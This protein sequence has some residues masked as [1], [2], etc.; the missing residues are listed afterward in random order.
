MVTRGR[1]NGT[2]GQSHKLTRCKIK[3]CILHLQ[4]QKMDV[5]FVA[6]TTPSG[7]RT[8]VSPVA[9]AY[10]TTRPTVLEAVNPPD[11]RC[12][13]SR[14]CATSIC[15]P[16]VSIIYRMLCFANLSWHHGAFQYVCEINPPDAGSLPLLLMI[17]KL[18]CVR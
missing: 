13:P 10:S 6:I 12:C 7:N 4:N 17:M 3:I 9:G 14:N 18:V 8:R 15:W 16:L 2:V 5:S 1:C 11:V